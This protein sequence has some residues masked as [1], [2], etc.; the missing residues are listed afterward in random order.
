VVP[1][2]ATVDAIEFRIRPDRLE[3]RNLVAFRQLYP[4]GRNLVVAPGVREPHEFRLGG[5]VVRAAG[6]AERLAAVS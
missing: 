6:C 4:D 2:G 5:L 1:R 3:A